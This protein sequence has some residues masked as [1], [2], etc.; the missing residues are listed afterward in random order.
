LLRLFGVIRH[1]PRALCVLAGVTTAVVL[2]ACS[3][4]TSL[5]SPAT[6]ENFDRQFGVYALTGSSASL[7]AGYQFTTES[8]VRPQVLNTGAL[9]FDVAFDITGD[10]KALVLTAKKVVP[11]PPAGVP[12]VGFLRL[13]AVY[14][15]LLK[16]PTS[17]YVEDTVTTLAVGQAVLVRLAGSGCVYGEPY[18]AKLTID[19]INVAERRL[20]VRALVNR[21]CGYV[22]LEAGVPTK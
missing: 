20:L 10:G 7:P 9:N 12:S 18:Y 21:N 15:Q 19:S 2:G 13:T 11:L 22:S 16:A 3:D 14:E 17:G 4:T 1:R 8:V 5:L 6:N